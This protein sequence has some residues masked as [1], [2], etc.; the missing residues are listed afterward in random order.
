MNKFIYTLGITALM[1]F[2]AIQAQ[3]P[4]VTKKDSVSKWELNIGINPMSTKLKSDL[5]EDLTKSKNGI[6]FNVDVAYTFLQ[7]SRYKLAVSLGLGY[8]LYNSQINMNYEESLWTNDKD[9][10]FY[11]HEKA[12]NLT[13]DRKIHY[14]SIP[15]L[16]RNSFELCKKVD[17]Y[18][19]VGLFYSFALSGKYES[20]AI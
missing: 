13:E 4:E 11:L 12:D 8:N 15:L 19:N 10:R 1:S 17:V 14:L 20:E 5:F 2:T 9:E 3:T 18:A 7:V 16:F 6:G